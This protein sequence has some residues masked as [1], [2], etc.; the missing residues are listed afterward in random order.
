MAQG[1]TR[2]LSSALQPEAVTKFLMERVTEKLAAA[3][4]KFTVTV[5]G[6]RSPTANG[7]SAIGEAICTQAEAIQARCFYIAVPACLFC[8]SEVAPNAA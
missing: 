4:I 6:Y 2:V 3:G 5:L 8:L 7:L 1:N